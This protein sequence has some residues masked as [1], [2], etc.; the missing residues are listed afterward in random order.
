ME[1]II[2]QFRNL[3]SHSNLS[4]DISSQREIII[5]LFFLKHINDVSDNPH[6]STRFIIPD[7]ARLSFVY[8]S[9]N[10]YDFKEVFAQAF[11]SLEKNNSALKGTFSVFEF[12]SFNKVQIDFIK[13][14]VTKIFDYNTSKETFRFSRFVELLLSKLSEYEG[15]HITSHTTPK[16]LAILMTRLLGLNS[17]YS[18]LDSTCG[19]GGFFSE[20][21]DCYPYSNFSFFGQEINPKIL[22]ISKLRFAFESRSKF[23]FGEPKDTLIENQFN[24]LKF[25]GIIMH[26]PFNQR[27]WFSEKLD[28]DPRFSEVIPSRRNANYAWLQHVSHHLNSQGR[29]VILLPQNSLITSTKSERLIRK[30][31]VDNNLLEAVIDLPSGVLDYSGLKTSIWVLN[32]NKL[33][34]E[35]YFLDA[36]ELSRKESRTVSFPE[37]SIDHIVSI[38]EN[39]TEIPFVSKVVSGDDLRTNDYSL[40][41]TKYINDALLEEISMPRKLGYILSNK[42]LEKF[43]EHRILK[44]LS[45]KD[46]SMTPENFMIKMSNL[47]EK[48]IKNNHYLFRGKA[49]LMATLGDKLKP[50]F[51]DSGNRYIAIQ[52]NIAVFEVNEEKVLIEYLV[53]E[54][55]KD[56]VKIQIAGLISG[57]TI[58]YI[59]K[60]DLTSIVIDLPESKN[61]QREIVKRENTI[62]FENMLLETGWKK[63]LDEI[64]AEQEAYLKS[65]RHMINQDVSSLNSLV[66]YIEDEFISRKD[67]IK[68]NTVL[69]DRYGT[70]MKELLESLNDTVK[71]ISNQVNLL[72][73]N[74]DA[75]NK[76]VF[77]VKTFLKTLV[78]REKS[79]KYDIIEIYDDNQSNTKILADKNLFREMF[80]SILN[81]AV[82][83][84]FVDD[85]LKNVFKITLKDNDKYLELLMENNGK[86]L[87]EGITKMSYTTKSMVAGKTGNTGLGGYNVGVFAKTHGFDWELIDS[88]EK[89]FK[90]GVLIK[91]KKYDEV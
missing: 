70:T 49:L 66:Q 29:G 37:S 36:Q 6:L 8:N 31:L 56:Y 75:I 9:L 54:L 50:S 82:R 88:P 78:R 74:I 30:S 11:Y 24:N 62:R 38:F 39:F 59:R 33:R 69:D 15:K 13:L 32:K 22:A 43:R 21:I 64:K 14:L 28:K 26:P 58:N 81:N 72:S 42:K 65:K 87:P 5:S 76:E 25:D 12:D 63:E 52:Q 57:S 18:V 34:K 71:L 77:N 53:N 2:R 1:K 83:H 10:R 45:I 80:K 91:L 90:V 84:G 35:F 44:S 79:R 47:K 60:K 73:N 55:Y 7:N 51:I 89:E 86:K 67:G 48:E 4:V 16:S 41:P 3:I 27:D 20:I 17:G 85:S 19:S 23:E 61:Y 40:L 46:L 68:L